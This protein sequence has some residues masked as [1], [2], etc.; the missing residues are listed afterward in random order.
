MAGEFSLMSILHNQ[1]TDHRANVAPGAIPKGNMPNLSFEEACNILSM[2]EKYPEL[3]AMDNDGKRAFIEERRI[4]AH[5]EMT[6]YQME[7]DQLE[8]ESAG[9]KHH[10][11]HMKGLVE[12]MDDAKLEKP[13]A[14]HYRDLRAA[15]ASGNTIYVHK[16]VSAVTPALDYEKEVFRFAQVMVV[17]HDWAA[18]FANADMGDAPVNLPYDLCAFEFQYSGIPTIVFATSFLGEVAFCYMFKWNGI[19]TIPAFCSSLG[20]DFSIGDIP[21]Q[22]K[23]ICVALDAGIAYSEVRREKHEGIIGKSSNPLRDYNVVV[24]S[25]RTRAQPTLSLPSGR[26]VRLHFRRGHWRHFGNHKTWIKWMLVGDPD[27]GFVDKHYRL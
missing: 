23:A 5:R 15:V 20:G 27:L 12:W 21:K 24:L 7:I 3:K 1:I 11:A 22:I 16:D 4:H 25:S 19:W 6:S 14:P 26:H 9:L 17:E 13:S 18:A 10:S 8:K 2:L